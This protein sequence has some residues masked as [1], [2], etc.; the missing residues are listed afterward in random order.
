MNNFDSFQVVI[1]ENKRRF[2]LIVLLTTFQ[3][4]FKLGD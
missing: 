4:A 2:S 1:F 3:T